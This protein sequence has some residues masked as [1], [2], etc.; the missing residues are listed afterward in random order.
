MSIAIQEEVLV[1]KQ[2]RKYDV[3]MP[4]DPVSGSCLWCMFGKLDC[5]HSPI[6]LTCTNEKSSNYKKRTKFPTRKTCKKWRYKF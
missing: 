6:R 4:L 3:L 5:E 1:L 2:N